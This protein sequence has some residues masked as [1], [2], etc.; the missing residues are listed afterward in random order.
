MEYDHSAAPLAEAVQAYRDAGTLPFTTPGHKRGKGVPAATAALLGAETFANDIPLASGV[1]DTHLSRDVLGQA[2]RLAADAYGAAR[3]F[4]LLNGSTLGN[5]AAILS[6]AGP[7][8]EVIVA[9]NF[10]KSMLSALILSGARPIYIY[11]QHDPAMEVAHAIRPA[12]VAAMLAAH[13]RARALLLVSPSYFGVASDLAAI[14]ALCHQRGV[15]LV[16]DE[17]WGPHFPF[18][19]ALPPSAMASGADAGVTSIHKVLTGL[20]QSSILN[21]Q[22]NLIDPSRVA[23]WLGLLQ[24]TSPSALILASID[25]CRRQMVLH[26]RELLSGTLALGARAREA[27]NA[28]PGLSVLGAELVG[29]YGVAAVDSTKLVVDVRGSGAS[30]YAVDVWLRQRHGITVE[31][32]DHRRVVALLSVAD[33][34]QSAGRLIEALQQFAASAPGDSGTPPVAA[35]EVATLRTESA[36]TPREAFFAPAQAVPLDEAIGRVAAE[37]VTPYPPGIPLLAPGELVTRPIVEYLHAG[38]SAGMHVSG[39]ADQSLGTLRV[40]G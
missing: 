37:V 14:A 23:S 40:V 18:H 26:G 11:P 7:G 34:E 27:L 38:R 12:D 33:D 15:P 2:E 25:A 21:L 10:H 28:T 30:G 22:G 36:M 20:T 24:T 3:T 16:V 39:V 29:Q 4:F 13:P 8:D 6:V 5:Q 9:R 35:V 1:D 31:M 17:A 19:P 32:S